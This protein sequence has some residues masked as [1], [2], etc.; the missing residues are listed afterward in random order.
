MTRAIVAAGRYLLPFVGSTK[1][2]REQYGD[3]IQKFDAAGTLLHG[4]LD[5]RPE[6]LRRLAGD[7]LPI[8]HARGTIGERP[9]RP[10]S[11]RTHVRVG[12]RRPPRRS[13]PRQ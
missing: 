7:R 11:M 4:E 2:S 6:R 12:E 3:R 8:V 10:L 5:L 9:C 13:D 1:P